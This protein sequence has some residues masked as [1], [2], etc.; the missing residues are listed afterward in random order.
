MIIG[1]NLTRLF[2]R[3]SKSRNHLSVQLVLYGA[4]RP[5]SRSALSRRRRL[6]DRNVLQICPCGFGVPNVY[7]L[8][9]GISL[10]ISHIF[11][12]AFSEQ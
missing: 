2:C 12:N 5:S 8:F 10:L 9:N 7:E 11:A 4:V 1:M 3:R 6:I